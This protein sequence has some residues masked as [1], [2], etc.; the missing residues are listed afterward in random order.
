MNR[1][2]EDQLYA[3]VAREIAANE[4]H[5]APMARAA[6]M[7]AGNPDAAKGYY[8][9]FRVEQLARQVS[10]EAQRHQ[11]EANRAAE[12]AAQ[13]RREEAIAQLEAK[14]AQLETEAVEFVRAV[15]RKAAPFLKTTGIVLGTIVVAAFMLFL[16]LFVIFLIWFIIWGWL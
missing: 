8:I 12:A 13:E 11:L 10:K 3:H 6:A 2:V 4:F 7:A 1:D 16:V 15:P 9:T 14:A 5:P